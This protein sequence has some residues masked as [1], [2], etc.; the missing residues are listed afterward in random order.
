MRIKCLFIQRNEQ[1]AGQYAP[2]LL[3]AVDEFTNEEAPTWFPDECAKELESVGDDLAGKAIVE[4]EVDQ[5]QLRQ[6]L[7]GKKTLKADIITESP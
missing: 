3:V 4:L 2:E 6:I 7:I 1:Y 5:E